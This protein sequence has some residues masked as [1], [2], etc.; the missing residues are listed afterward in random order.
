[1]CIRDRSRS[2][3]SPRPAM[4]PHPQG[5][6]AV[7]RCVSARPQPP[8]PYAPGTGYGGPCRYGAGLPTQPEAAT[9]AGVAAKHCRGLAAPGCAAGGRRGLRA[10]RAKP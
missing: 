10:Q 4:H 7:R 6:P 1:M 8:R 9:S 5:T 3:G 2:G